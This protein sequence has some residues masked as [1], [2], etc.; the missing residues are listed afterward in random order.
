[1]KS[2]AIEGKYL[3]DHE[4]ITKVL[5]D[6]HYTTFTPKWILDQWNAIVE[7]NDALGLWVIGSKDE[8]LTEELERIKTSLDRLEPGW[9][10]RLEREGRVIKPAEPSSGRNVG[11]GSRRR[12]G[13][14]VG[15]N[16]KKFFGGR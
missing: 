10:Q 1:M 2:R 8:E 9:R 6:W 5:C 12:R 15:A 13:S 4:T 11:E 7:K 16:V 14:S 3:L